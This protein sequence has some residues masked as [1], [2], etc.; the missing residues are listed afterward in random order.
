MSDPHRV[1]WGVLSLSDL[2]QFRVYENR[3]INMNEFYLTEKSQRDKPWDKHRSQAQDVQN[4]YALTEYGHYSERIKNCSP[5]LIFDVFDHPE[6]GEKYK[7]KG[8]RFCR[9]RHCPACQWRKTL[10]KIARFHAS[11]PKLIS[12]YPKLRYI[13]LTLTVRNCEITELKATIQHMNKSYQRLYERKACPGL[14]YIKAVEVTRGQLGDAH[15]HLH[16]LMA[17]KESYFKSKGYLSQSKWQELWKKSARLCY[18][19]IVDV[20]AIRKAKGSD[21]ESHPLMKNVVEV[22]K[23]TVKPEDLAS[24][25][26]WLEELTTQMHRVR[27]VAFGG[28]FRDYMSDQEI[29]EQEM[30]QGDEQEQDAEAAD[31]QA[32]MGWRPEERR[33]KGHYRETK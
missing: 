26:Q 29:S 32:V 33:Y 21:S 6:K 31:R 17:V 20:R 19:P 12:D 10:A 15:P 14:G 28:L 3:Q 22:A 13:F 7:L 11:I 2:R 25:P 16:I 8:A 30:I 23:Y 18:D 1:C 4:L 27:A 9:C 24:D 5:W